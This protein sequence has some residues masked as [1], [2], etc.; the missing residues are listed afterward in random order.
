MQPTT[1]DEA[2]GLAHDGQ[3]AGGDGS[4]NGDADDAGDG[5]GD[6]PV[7]KVMWC[8]ACLLARSTLGGGGRGASCGLP[9]FYLIFRIFF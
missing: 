7:W 8:G 5:G 9:V 6:R 1:P 3:G 4:G 2:Q